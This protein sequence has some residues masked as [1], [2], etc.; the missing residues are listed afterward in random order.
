MG[1]EVTGSE[2]VVNEGSVKVRVQRAQVQIQ[3]QR[4]M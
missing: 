1:A 3:V 4:F 2:C